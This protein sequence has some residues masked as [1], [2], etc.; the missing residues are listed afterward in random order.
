[1]KEGAQVM[2]KRD[3]FKCQLCG[4]GKDDQAILE[5]DHRQSISEGGETSEDNLWTLCFEC[6]RGKHSQ[7]L[8]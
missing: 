4:K 3:N 6:N 5:V 2:L 8:N 7:S 1:M